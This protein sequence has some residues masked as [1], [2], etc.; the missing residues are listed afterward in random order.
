MTPHDRLKEIIALLKKTSEER[1]NEAISE[2]LGY[3]R[4][5]VSDILGGKKIN[6]RFCSRLQ[7]RYGINGDWIMTGAGE[8]LDRTQPAHRLD[9]PGT[10][11]RGRKRRSGW[12]GVPVFDA[13]VLSIINGESAPVDHI[14]LRRFK[15]CAFCILVS[16][17]DMCPRVCNGDYIFC[18]EIT[19]SEIIM[20]DDHL[21][22]THN[23]VAIAAGIYPPDAAQD[24][25][26][27]KQQASSKPPTSLALSAIHKI[28]RIRGVI[29]TF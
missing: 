1:T 27:L 4:N 12:A 14:R 8:M 20:G 3:T 25:I 11:Y 18:Q 19:I 28:Y 5:Y 22:L 29:K 7:Q 2:R 23:G 24:H 16:G 13:P 17:N 26:L 21:V 6:K 10:S 9:D 15:D